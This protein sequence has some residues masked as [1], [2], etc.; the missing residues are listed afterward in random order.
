MF[1]VIPLLSSKQYFEYNS[2]FIMDNDNKLFDKD[3]CFEIAKNILFILSLNFSCFSLFSL[4]FSLFDLYFLFE[5]K[6]CLKE[7]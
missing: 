3:K 4:I 1:A 5:E 2:K 6:S 7:L